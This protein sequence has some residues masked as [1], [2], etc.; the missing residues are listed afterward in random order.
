MKV[1]YFNCELKRSLKCVILAVFF[2]ALM[3]KRKKKKKK[4][5]GLT[6]IQTLNRWI[7]VIY[8]L[9]INPDNNQFPVGLI[10]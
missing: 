4:N 2:N 9:V 3:K 8:G 1:V 7:P 5:L 6:R 10:A